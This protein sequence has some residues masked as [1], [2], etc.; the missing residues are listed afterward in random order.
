MI[1]LKLLTSAWSIQSHGSSHCKSHFHRRPHS[2]GQKHQKMYKS[3]SV[4]IFEILNWHNAYPLA[5]LTIMVRPHITYP[6]RMNLKREF[7]R[8]K[9]KT[10]HLVHLRAD[11]A[12]AVTIWR[13]LAC[14]AR[15]IFIV[16]LNFSWTPSWRPIG[17][18]DFVLGGLW[19][20]RPWEVVW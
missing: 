9:N 2:P 7:E 18:L 10:I 8:E 6:F 14:R 1:I 3:E 5:L 16:K 17:P 19:A 11:Q 4:W 15:S 20:L 12:V 13:C